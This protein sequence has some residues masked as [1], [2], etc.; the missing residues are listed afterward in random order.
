MKRVQGQNKRGYPCERSEEFIK[1]SRFLTPPKAEFGMTVFL[2]RR[3]FWITTGRAFTLLEMLTALAI[4]ALLIGLLI[5]AI[6]KIQTTAQTVKQKAQFHAIEVALEAFRSDVGDYPPSRQANTA[7][8]ASEPPG[9]YGAQKLAEAVV[10]LDGFGF[11]PWSKFRSDGK[12]DVNGNGTYELVYDVVNGIKDGSTT[13]QTAA[14]NLKARKGPYLELEKANAVKVSSVY[15]SNL[16][17]NLN[18]YVLVDMFLK[19]M[20]TGKKTGIPI[21]YFRADTSQSILDPL[22][23]QDSIYDIEHN[24][25][26]FVFPKVPWDVSLNHP[27]RDDIKGTFY[28]RITNPNFPGTET[29]NYVDARPYRTDSFILLSAGPDGLYG[30]P[31]DVYNF[32]ES[33]K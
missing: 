5:P 22:D 24:F 11:H 17:V 6:G 18:T 30:T 19:K 9:Y 33:E 13:V 29:N 7:P 31:D 8:P 32:D 3:R 10:G 20:A 14:D 16:N 2:R 25:M 23:T 26:G 1:H 4:I 27:M 12:A 15:S 21:L 28:R